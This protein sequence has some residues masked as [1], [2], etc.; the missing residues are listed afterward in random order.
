MCPTGQPD[1]HSVPVG[2]RWLVAPDGGHR[3]GVRSEL[4]PAHVPIRP[5]AAMITSARFRPHPDLR[6][7]PVECPQGV[8]KRCRPLLPSRGRAAET[9]GSSSTQV[10]YRKDC[11]SNL[12]DHSRSGANPAAQGTTVPRP[13]RSP[14]YRGRGTPD[15]AGARRRCPGSSR[16]WGK[17]R[18]GAGSPGR[19]CPRP[20]ALSG[21]QP[22][23]ARFRQRPVMQ[24]RAD[25][26]DGADGGDQLFTEVG[27]GIIYGLSAAR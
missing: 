27:Q 10:V 9:T 13:K 11:I 26:D 7:K 4:S 1:R 6:R 2:L 14:A 22:L 20:C 12:V 3:A 17:S 16:R 5:A 23:R 8:M 24:L 18:C 19:P 25:L 15:L 21:D